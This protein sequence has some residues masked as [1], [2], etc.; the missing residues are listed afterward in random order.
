MESRGYPLPIFNPVPLSYDFLYRHYFNFILKDIFRIFI[1]DGLPETINERFFK[2]TLFL[3]GKVT[4]FKDK[5]NDKLLAL[6]G[7]PSGQQDIY[8]VPE[9][10]IVS[11]P[12]L[13]KPYNLKRGVDCEVVYCSDIDVYNQFEFGGLYTLV[14][15][16]ATMLADGDL[17]ISVAQKNKRLINVLAAED[18]NTKNSI[19]VVIKKQYS[20][21][22]Y[23]V[24]MKSLID[25]V[26][27]VPI[28]EKGTNQDLMQLIEAQQY[29]LSH[30]YESLGL[31]THDQMKKERLITAEVNDN[32]NIAKLNIDDILASI[33]EGLDRVNAMFGTNISVKLNPVL[34]VQSNPEEQQSDEASEEEP[35][36]QQSDEASEEEPKEQQSDETSEEEP[37]EQ[38]SDEASEEEPE[39]QQSDETSEEEP[40]EQQSDETSEEE[41]EEQQSD[42]EPE[43][44][45]NVEITVNDNATAEIVVT[46]GDV[47]GLGEP[48]DVEADSNDG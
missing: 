8:Y 40:E 38:Q 9:E 31:Q 36:E 29:I 14:A 25:N 17:S 30:F 44:T 24:V 32:D 37:E 10:M 6:N 22:P 46:G 4:F 26:Q 28:V 11:N 34:I 39:E 48:E 35:K 45:I 41:P 18:Q 2:Y 13:L 16:T 47:D 7:A 12:R 33:Q 5:D 21:E 19:D 27:S 1:F 3:Y 23:A 15:K 20:G 42:E 43:Q